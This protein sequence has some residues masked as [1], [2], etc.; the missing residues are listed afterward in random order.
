MHTY[1]HTYYICICMYISLYTC[2]SCKPIDQSSLQHTCVCACVYIC[3][4][5]Y[6]CIYVYGCVSCSYSVVYIKSTH[7]CIQNQTS[8][9][10]RVV[11]LKSCFFSIMEYTKSSWTSAIVR[12]D[13][14]HHTCGQLIYYHACVQ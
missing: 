2:I 1:T 7:A 9:N 10:E 5:A 6:L 13:D 14:Y 8:A 11:E 3:V 12:Q 4:C